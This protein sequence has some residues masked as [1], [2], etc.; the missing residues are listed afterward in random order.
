MYPFCFSSLFILNGEQTS[1]NEYF[2][3]PHRVIVKIREVNLWTCSFKCV[4]LANTS[5]LGPTLV[6]CLSRA[7]WKVLVWVLWSFTKLGGWVCVLHTRVHA[8]SK[9]QVTYVDLGSQW[10]ELAQ[11]MRAGLSG[12]PVMGPLSLMGNT[13]Q[14]RFIEGSL[15]TSQPT[16]SLGVVRRKGT[17]ETQ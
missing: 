10:P 15:G 11:I 9:E 7:T 12:G 3:L 8:R 13:N 17:E 6:F 5:Y 1:G 14:G 4:S 16:G 2:C